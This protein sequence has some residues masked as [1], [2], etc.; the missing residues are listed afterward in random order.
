ML[1]KV[2]SHEIHHLTFCMELHSEEIQSV[3]VFYSTIICFHYNLVCFFTALRLAYFI[4]SI[5]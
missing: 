5:L 2:K 3:H 4:L 1:L